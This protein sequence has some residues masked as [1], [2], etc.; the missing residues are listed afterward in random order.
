MKDGEWVKYKTGSGYGWVNEV[1]NAIAWKTYKYASKQGNPYAQL[2]LGI[3][4]A[5][6]CHMAFE[7]YL[8]QAG[9]V[10]SVV[11]WFILGAAYQC[12]KVADYPVFWEKT[13]PIT[14]EQFVRWKEN[15]Q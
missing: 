14:P 2:L 10:Q 6:A 1:K 5:I 3:M 11:W 7:G 4:I 9:A 15:K 12:D 13:D 8:L